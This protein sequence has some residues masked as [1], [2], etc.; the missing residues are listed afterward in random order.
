[1]YIESEMMERV[2]KVQWE[3]K[4]REIVPPSLLVEL[5]QAP[6]EK[7]MCINTGK[8]FPCS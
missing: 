2:G 7:K 5:H 4:I 1:M 3:R 6:G 8:T